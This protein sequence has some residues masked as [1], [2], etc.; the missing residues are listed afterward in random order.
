[1]KQE[2]I[3]TV[4]SEITRLLDN[5]ELSAALNKLSEFS[6]E[7][8][9]WQLQE[10]TNEIKTAYEYMLEYMR[11]GTLDPQRHV[12]HNQLLIRTYTLNDRL[13]LLLSKTAGTGL[14]FEKMRTY[15]KMPPRTFQEIQME[16]EYFTYQ[17]EEKYKGKGDTESIHTEELINLARRHEEAFTELFYSTWCSSFWDKSKETQAQEILQSGQ[18]QP[19]VKQFFITA[20]TFGVLKYLDPHKLSV[21]LSAYHATDLA[22]SQRALVGIALICYKYDTR[23]LLYPE[24]AGHLSLLQEEAAFVSD[25]GAIQLQFLYSR[26]SKRTEKRIKDE[27]L[28]QFMK[29]NQMRADSFH[30]LE[31]EN[32][33]ENMEKN[34]DWEEQMRNSGVEE[35]LNEFQTMMQEGEDVFLAS[36][37]QVKNYSFFHEPSNW[38]LPFTILHSHIL[39]TLKNERQK[40]LR[41]LEVITQ[42]GTLCDSDKYSFSLTIAGIPEVQKGAVLTQLSMQEEEFREMSKKMESDT[43]FRKREESKHYIQDLY[44]FLNLHPRKREFENPFQNDLY[45]FSCHTLAP[46]LGSINAKIPVAEFLFRKELWSEAETVYRQI[47]DQ[48]GDSVDIYQKMGYCM[49][50]QMK[51]DRALEMFQKADLLKPGQKWVVRNMAFCYRQL[52]EYEKALSCYEQLKSGQSAPSLA[53]SMQIG[54]CLLYMERLNEALNSFFEAEF[55]DEKSTRPWRAIA[56]CS[57]LSGKLEQSQRYCKRLL[58][59]PAPAKE[60]YLNAAHTEWGLGNTP[61]AVALYKKSIGGYGGME[62]FLRSFENDRKHLIAQGIAADDIP[63]MIDLL[64]TGN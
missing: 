60:D 4:Y 43:Q 13:F 24:I 61:E 25:L 5:K 11:M 52:G 27:L 47:L 14:F 44:R 55:T 45:L 20:L 50:Q 41:I 64:Q 31:D 36:F 18:V 10:E 29:N 54:T 16:L 58:Q 7:S 19:F 21:I 9:D 59:Q 26:E 40:N 8:H 38:L 37:A 57:F 35:L 53:L 33:L 22:V 23:L 28:P 12:L 39:N 51:Y 3:Y 42:F 46:S 34:P 56:W 15:E 63:L 49:Q 32:M 62:P 17:Y 1:M 48:K 30:F 2:S 6:I